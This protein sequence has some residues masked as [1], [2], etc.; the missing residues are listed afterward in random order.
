MKRLAML[1][2]ILLL[3]PACGSPSAQANSQTRI[4]AYLQ[5]KGS[6]TMVNLAQA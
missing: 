6:D 3:L 1:A 5:N 4:A 2:L